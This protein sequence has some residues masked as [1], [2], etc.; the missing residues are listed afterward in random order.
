MTCYCEQHTHQCL[1]QVPIFKHLSETE[2]QSVSEIT[3]EKEYKKGDVIYQAGQLFHHLMVLSKGK[4]KLSRISTNGKEQVIRVVEAGDFIGELSVLNNQA[5]REFATV[6]QDV[7]MCIVDGHRLKEL[8]AQQPTIA[9][10]IMETLTTR[11]D[12]AEQV[13]QTNSNSSVDYRIAQKLLSL[14]DEK[15]YIELEM[16]KKDMSNLLAIT[17][18]T[19]SRKLSLFELKAWIKQKGQR[20]IIIMDEEALQNV[21]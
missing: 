3:Y 4:V 14:A 16:S 2:Q 7:T 13:I 5:Q 1:H 8:M 18:E 21:E 17:Q 12:E 10:K 20:T 11:L 15:G 19:F 9:F 6:I